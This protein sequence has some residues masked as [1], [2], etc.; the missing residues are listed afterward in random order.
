M[1]IIPMQCILLIVEIIGCKNGNLVSVRSY[2]KEYAILNPSNIGAANAVTVAGST[3]DPG[4]WLYQFNNPT[5]ITLDQYSFIYVL[6][7]G[8]SRVQKWAAGA[9]YGVII[10]SAVMSSPIGM[11]FDLQGNF[12]ITDTSYHRVLSFAVTCRKSEYTVF[13]FY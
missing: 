10:I 4:A 6:D 7:Q 8:N 5:A 2:Y 9:P 11:E 3:S 1:L 13:K 12:V